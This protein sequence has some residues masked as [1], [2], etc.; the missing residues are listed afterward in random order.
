M[1]SKKTIIGAVLTVHMPLVT[2][3]LAYS[4]AIKESYILKTRWQLRTFFD[5]SIYLLSTQFI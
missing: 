5:L 3:M 4:L 2:D 1:G